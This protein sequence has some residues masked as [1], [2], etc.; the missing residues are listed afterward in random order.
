M[1]NPIESELK[2][3][4]TKQGQNTDFYIIFNLKRFDNSMSWLGFIRIR[5]SYT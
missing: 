4:L 3:D 2:L 1:Y 5:E